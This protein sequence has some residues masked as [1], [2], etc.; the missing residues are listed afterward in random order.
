MHP[1]EIFI[2]FVFFLIIVVIAIVVAVNLNKVIRR[3]VPGDPDTATSLQ[4]ALLPIWF[5][6]TFVFIFSV[7][8]SINSKGELLISLGTSL[9][10]AGASLVIGAFLGFL[11]GIPKVARPP[12]QIPSARNTVVESSGD[13]NKDSLTGTL[14]TVQSK[15]QDFTDGKYTDNTNIEEVSDWLT[16]ML[17]GIGLV[18]LKN[19]PMYIT[20]LHQR[21]EVTLGNGIFGVAIS[22]H[23]LISGF[24]VGY[25]GA[26]LFLPNAFN[27]NYSKEVLN[28]SETINS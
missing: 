2:G 23:F 18:Q 13:S 15:A 21:F 4:S 19:L 24:F 6:L 11:F 12:A 1:L 9:A 8:R 3:K 26:R 20:E 14:N 25:L 17:V 16:K 28:N 7:G 27:R 10:V 22:I 5:G